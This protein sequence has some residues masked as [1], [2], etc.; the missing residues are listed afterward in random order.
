MTAHAY[1]CLKITSIS[2][3]YSEVHEIPLES[4]STNCGLKSFCK[5]L[6]YG[7]LGLPKHHIEKRIL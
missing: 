1:K 4:I 7:G 5:N 2:K 6:R 3:K